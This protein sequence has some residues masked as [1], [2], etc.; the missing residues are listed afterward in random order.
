MSKKC[1]YLHLFCMQWD[2]EGFVCGDIV[3]LLLWSPVLH[4]ILAVA[5]IS[6]G[7][8]VVLVDAVD[9]LVSDVSAACWPSDSIGFLATIVAFR[10]RY[11]IRSPMA[12]GLP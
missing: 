10:R 7:V 4:S 12:I 2:F 11:S 8:P 9:P 5:R 1:V 6:V 3:Q